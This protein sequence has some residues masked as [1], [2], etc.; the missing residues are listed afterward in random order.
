MKF[1]WGQ[2]R[3]LGGGSV[4]GRGWFVGVDPGQSG[5]SWGGYGG[6]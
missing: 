3:G 5:W 2:D 6:C 4:G 1:T